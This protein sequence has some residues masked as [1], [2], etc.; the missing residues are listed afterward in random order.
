M[1]VSN[2]QTL[3]AVGD[4]PRGI[5]GGSVGSEESLG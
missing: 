2:L 5:P 3:E 1:V 4:K